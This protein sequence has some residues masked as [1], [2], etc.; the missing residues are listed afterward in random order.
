[1]PITLI[2]TVAP[3]WRIS[4]NIQL[5]TGARMNLTKNCRHSWLWGLDLFGRKLQWLQCSSLSLATCNAIPGLKPFFTRKTYRN[6]VASW[7]G[8]AMRHKVP[9]NII[10][11]FLQAGATLGLSL[12]FCNCNPLVRFHNLYKSL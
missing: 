3:I 6:S 8:F 2:L 11:A 5:L 4:M 10:S 7:K 9:I 1:M 12:F